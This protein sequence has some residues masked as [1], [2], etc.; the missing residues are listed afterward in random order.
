MNTGVRSRP[1]RVRPVVVGGQLL[2]SLCITLL[3]PACL[4]A[5][6]L[7]VEGG[8]TA[9]KIAR[10]WGYRNK[11]IEPGKAKTIY[12]KGKWTRHRHSPSRLGSSPR[13]CLL[14]APPP[15]ARPPARRRRRVLI[16]EC[17]RGLQATSGGGLSRRSA[18]RLTRRPLLISGH[19]CRASFSV[20]PR[21]QLSC[22]YRQRRSLTASVR[23]SRVQRLGWVGG[24]PGFV[25]GAVYR[26]VAVSARQRYRALAG[27]RMEAELQAHN[28]EVVA[29]MLEPIQ[30]EAGIV[31]PDPGYL[32]GPP[33]FHLLPP[34]ARR[35]ASKF[36]LRFASASKLL[37]G[38]LCTPL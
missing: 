25:C 26:C 10:R 34:V 18:H 15:P 28:G 9:N 23:C 36:L 32:T 19:S 31:V 27:C 6:P 22:C 33:N 3:L 13:G 8:E 38:P 35:S 12:A 29:V 1:N 14:N 17:R 24:A 16:G 5:P 4:A 2:Q 7:Q 11:A 21:L 30:G 37:C 20:R